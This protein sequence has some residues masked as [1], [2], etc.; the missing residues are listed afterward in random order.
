VVVLNPK[1]EAARQYEHLRAERIRLRAAKGRLTHQEEADYGAL[2][3]TCWQQMTEAEQAEADVTQPFEA[4]LEQWRKRSPDSK[5]AMLSFLT[6]TAENLEGTA[7]GNEDAGTLLVLTSVMKAVPQT[8]G[9]RYGT[10]LGS[11]E[12]LPADLAAQ[13]PH[14]RLGTPKTDILPISATAR[15]EELEQRLARVAELAHDR[16][17]DT[18]EERSKRLGKCAS[19][20]WDPVEEALSTDPLKRRS[21]LKWTS[22]AKQLALSEERADAAEAKA[23]TTLK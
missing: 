2:M 1:T 9:E 17:G 14:Y 8:F 6:R 18:L 23:A 5:A 13:H 12:G 16:D 10:L 7:D 22:L 15:I 4:L 21:T 3:D 11:A 19:I 20:A